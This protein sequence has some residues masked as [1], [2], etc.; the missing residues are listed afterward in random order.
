MKKSLLLIVLGVVL[1]VPAVAAK[2]C[3]NTGTLS[4]GWANPYSIDWSWSQDTDGAVSFYGVGVCSDTD[5]LNNLT[6]DTISQSATA[7][8]NIFCY[9]KLIAPVVTPWVNIMGGSMTDC[10]KKCA[11]TCSERYGMQK[12]EWEEYL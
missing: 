12:I 11:G 4:E 8:Q 6:V 9:C 2:R 3:I 7:S 5:P 10:Y 1:T